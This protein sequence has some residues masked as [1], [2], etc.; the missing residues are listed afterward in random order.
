MGFNSIWL[1]IVLEGTILTI[2]PLEGTLRSV[3]MANKKITIEKVV[4]GLDC[5]CSFWAYFFGGSYPVTISATMVK[6]YT[7]KCHDS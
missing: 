2:C 4:E 3:I 1:R 6:S 5:D 7:K